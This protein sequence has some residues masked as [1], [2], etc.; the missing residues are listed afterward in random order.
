VVDAVPRHWDARERALV[1]L[2]LEAEVALDHH[3]DL[4][5][6]EDH[7]LPDRVD[8]PLDERELLLRLL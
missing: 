5:R 6:R 8:V 1:V 7:P 2:G 4:A 3:D